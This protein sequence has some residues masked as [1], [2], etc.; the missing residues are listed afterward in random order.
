MAPEETTVLL[1]IWSHFKL[2]GGWPQKL[3]LWSQLRNLNLNLDEL[4]S[5]A[6]WLSISSIGD[7]VSVG[8]ETLLEIPEA[9]TLLEPLPRFLQFLARRF[10]EEPDLD[11]ER[12][13]QG[14]EVGAESFIQFWKD[15]SEARLAA[16]LLWNLRSGLGGWG[17]PHS[18]FYFRPR[19]DILRYEKVESLEQYL[20]ASVPPKEGTVRH[21]PQGQHL[22]LLQAVYAHIQKT[23]QWPL[24]A[25]FTLQ[26]RERLGYLPHLVMA[27]TPSFIHPQSR[28]ER[29]ARIHLRARA[30]PVVAGETGCALALSIIRTLVELL[31]EQGAKKKF[32]IGQI[33]GKLKLPEEQ[34]LPVAMLLEQDGWGS[35]D[36][37]DFGLKDWQVELRTH[38]ID[39]LK[40]VRTWEEY[41]R[42]CDRYSPTVWFPPMEPPTRSKAF[43]ASAGVIEQ[44]VALATPPVAPEAPPSPPRPA[45]ATGRPKVFIGHGNSQAWWALKDF[46]SNRLGLDPVEFNSTPTPGH[47]TVERLQK[48]LQECQL[49]VLVM[50]GEDEH[51]DGSRHARQNVVHEIGLF[52]VKLGF[53]RVLILVE[54]KCTV[55]SNIHGLTHLT[56]RSGMIDDCFERIRKAVEHL[57]PRA[58]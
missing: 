24:L 45:L 5:R 9:R 10:V 54:E 21:A 43:H 49:A 50:T 46:L 15:E 55:F 37:W 14:P 51:L 47:T 44:A 6:P 28:Y 20:S 7:T 36:G 27:L 26:H 57:L 35:V 42:V 41:V 18:E 29:P 58:G 34:V 25:E 31:V 12:G 23:R 16:K 52:Q 13:S 56:F 30:V 32:S 1:L 17:D 11:E 19:L 22:A 39:E 48:C 3:L 53:D 40:D 33:A 38:V 2:H 8:L 4:A